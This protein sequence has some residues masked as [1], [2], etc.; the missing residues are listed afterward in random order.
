MAVGWWGG[1]YEVGVGS[2]Y[3]LCSVGIN[4]FVIHTNI[5]RGEETYKNNLYNDIDSIRGETG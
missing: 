5:D 4:V 3:R 2:E 1:F